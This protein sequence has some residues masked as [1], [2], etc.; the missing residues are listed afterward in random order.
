MACL[1]LNTEHK[2]K[3]HEIAIEI[4]S[5][6][7]VLLVGLLI[8]TCPVAVRHGIVGYNMLLFGLFSVY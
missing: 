2:F 8:S 3:I 4:G 1:I 6:V 5:L 7:G